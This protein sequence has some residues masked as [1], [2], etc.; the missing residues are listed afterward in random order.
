MNYNY[1]N[2]ISLLKKQ[3]PFINNTELVYELL[4]EDILEGYRTPGSK[5]NQD[6]CSEIIGVSRSPIRD[7]LAKLISDGL[8]TKRTQKGYY[9]Y[10]ATMLDAKRLSEFRIA[11]ESVSG[12]LAI[13]RFNAPEIELMKN[14]CLQM[15]E[16]NRKDIKTLI[17][18]DI[19]FHRLLVESSKNEYLI[20]AYNKLA[21]MLKHIRNSSFT[22]DIYDYM[23]FSHKNILSS[24]ISK[25]S[26]AIESMIINHLEDNVEDLI[27]SNTYSYN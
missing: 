22:A 14:N 8:V 25:D 5:I 26:D 24:L 17:N 19:E 11:I 23:L 20:D 9:V 16:W 10:I 3:N 4:K 15:S 27:K 6:K 13:K 7:A 1:E 21:P 12:K 18:L 2:R